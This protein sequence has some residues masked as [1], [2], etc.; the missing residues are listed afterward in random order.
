[1]RRDGA[2]AVVT[3]PVGPTPECGTCMW[4]ARGRKRA[5]CTE[6]DDGCPQCGCAWWW[7]AP[8]WDEMYPT[9]PQ[10]G[11]MTAVAV[12]AFAALVWWLSPGGV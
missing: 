2:G 5:W 8:A 12:G 10:V 7:P 3:R 4:V 9:V 11:A 6:Y 1:M